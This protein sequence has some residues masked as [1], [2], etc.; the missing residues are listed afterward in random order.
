MPT[1]HD[2]IEILKNKPPYEVVAYS[3]WTEEDVVQM[4]TNLGY[5]LP[6]GEIEAI[7]ENFHTC[8]NADTGLNHYTLEE[9][10]TDYMEERED[11]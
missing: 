5:A 4:L 11:N 8:N 2:L 10:I 3:L 1:A 7:L 9:M 6:I